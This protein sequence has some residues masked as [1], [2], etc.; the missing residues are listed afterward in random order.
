M[1]ED[2]AARDKGCECP[3]SLRGNERGYIRR[4]DTGERIR[5]GARERDRRVGK[6]GRRS[7]PVGCD[8][9][10]RDAGGNGLRTVPDRALQ[11]IVSAAAPLPLGA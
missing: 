9:V 5:Q 6:A 8:D 3:G 2:Q 7:E 1:R 11:G 4:R 10:E